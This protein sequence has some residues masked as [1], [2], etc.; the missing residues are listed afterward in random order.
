MRSKLLKFCVSSFSSFLVD[1]LIYSL[2]VMILSDSAKMLLVSNITA[3]V[4]S[5]SFNYYM[6]RRFVFD[7]DKSKKSAASYFLLALFILAMN[8]IVLEL[9]T[10][11]I[12]INAF[13]AKVFTECIMFTVSW[14]IQS[15]VIFK[16]RKEARS[17]E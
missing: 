3:R 14:F 12:N 6:N 2:M 17:D 10:Q 7:A 1:Y 16:K 8:N 9:L 15:R 13:V 4:I 5:A 11:K